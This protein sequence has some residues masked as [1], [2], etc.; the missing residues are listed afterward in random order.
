MW[1]ESSESTEE[2]TGPLKQELKEK[3]YAQ[4]NNLLIPHQRQ[5]SDDDRDFVESFI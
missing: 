5:I 2:A 1:K 3:T 4:F